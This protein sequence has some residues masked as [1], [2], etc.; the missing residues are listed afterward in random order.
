MPNQKVF[1]D[2]SKYK[3]LSL[4]DKENLNFSAVVNPNIVFCLNE[5]YI[6]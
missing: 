1:W 2:K 4:N 6:V 5:K 3:I